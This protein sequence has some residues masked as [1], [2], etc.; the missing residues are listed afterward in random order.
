LPTFTKPKRRLPIQSR[1]QT[2]RFT[3][4]MLTGLIVPLIL[5]LIAGGVFI[6]PRI[7]S[8]AAGTNLNCTLIV[9]P[10]P[11]SAQGL[12]T[13]YK[14][15]ATD[16]NAGACNEANP[17]Q[18][19][20]VQGAVI[21]PATGQ[22][23]IYNPLIIDKGTQPAIAPVVPKL[24]TGGIVGLWFGFNGNALTL[25]GHNGS[26]QQGN[27][28]NG[29]N[30]SIFGQF[31][32]CNAEAFFTAAN[33]AIKQGKLQP[34]AL[35]T[36]ADGMP[37]PTVRDFSVV[38]QDQSDNVTTAYLFTPDGKIAQMTAA[39]TAALK[40]SQTLVNASDNRLLDISI[41]GALKCTPWTAPDLADNGNQVPALPLNEIQAAADQ[42]APVALVPSEDPMVLNNNNPDMNKLQAYRLGVDQPVPSAADSSTRTYCMNL[43]TVAPAR[44]QLDAQFTKNSPSPDPAAANSLFTFLAQRFNATYSANN[45]NCVGLLNKPSPIQVTTDGNGVAINATITTQGGNKG[46]VVTP[47][48]A[49]NGNV[50]Q[51][52]TGTTQINGQN[53]TLAF[54]SGANQINITCPAKKQ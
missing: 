45:L 52:C 4:L 3:P 32:D 26:L 22:I 37:C 7:A 25:V 16:P 50:V 29:A 46:N 17:L 33:T 12:A 51:N 34:P 5:L 18:S 31:A 47:N 2:K 53:C 9:P 44:L 40:N 48:C 54:D 20:F 28:V 35:N 13:P 1:R 21:D 41:D 6:L 39:N 15:V 36:A 11:L 14:L 27:C 10:N 43:A 24:P 30:G 23:S 49:I 19:A 8:H 42:G 38:D